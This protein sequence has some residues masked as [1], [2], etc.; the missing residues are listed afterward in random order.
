MA[1]AKMHANALAMTAPGRRP[2]LIGTAFELLTT[3]RFFQPVI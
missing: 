1:H 2:F 3:L